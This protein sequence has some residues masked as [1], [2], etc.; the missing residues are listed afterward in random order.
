MP[1][2]PRPGEPVY[3]TIEDHHYRLRFPL[4]VLKELDVEHNISVLRGESMAEAFRDPEKL[5][6]LLSC[7]LRT[8]NPEVTAEWI[9]DHV[10][11]SML[12][13][14]FPYIAYA[15]SGRWPDMSGLD[16]QPNPPQPEPASTG[17]LSGPSD[18][19]ISVLAKPNSGALR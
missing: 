2:K 15:A 4:R 11:A 7:G 18:A 1:N 17:L 12:L 5:A 8:D 6:I 14:I 19:T 3:V 16:N 9:E 13:E 10:E